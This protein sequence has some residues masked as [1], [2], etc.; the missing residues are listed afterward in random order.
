MDKQS[1][2]ESTA[3]M[4]AALCHDIKH[5]GRNNNFC[6]VT[7][8]PLALLYNNSSVLE[9]FHSSSCLQLLESVQL[10]KN[11]PFKE[12]ALIRSHII[13]NI[14]ATDMAEHFETISKFRVRREAS[15]FSGDV[16][17]DRRFVARL[18]LKAGDLGHACLPWHLHLQWTTRVTQE[19]YAQG[20]EERRL[21]LPVSALCNRE[22]VDNLPKSQK[23]FLEFVVA[24]ICQ[25]MSESQAEW[26]NQI[27]EEG[28]E[29]KLADASRRRVSSNKRRSALM[30][31]GPAL[32]AFNIELTCIQNLQDNKNRWQGDVTRDLEDVKDQLAQAKEE[33][34]ACIGIGLE[35]LLEVEFEQQI[36]QIHEESLI[37]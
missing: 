20:D 5:I 18:C 26:S 17:V 34:M 2:L 19:F 12:R 33:A 6:V 27:P 30:K 36:N 31:E 14:L 28:E 35:P 10:L 29:G 13:E 16:E 11:I 23:G 1:E 7:E 22:E 21:G 3:F 9:N 37:N 24:P 15:D 25:V 8:H 32:N 4:I